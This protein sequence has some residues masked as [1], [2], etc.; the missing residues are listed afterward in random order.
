MDT[1]SGLVASDI[2]TTYIS[3]S[4]NETVGAEYYQIMDQRSKKILGT[5]ID[6]TFTSVSL[7]PSTSYQFQVIP[8]YQS[9]LFSDKSGTLQ[10]TT[11]AVRKN[12]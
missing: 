11:A 5:T 3:I 8:A 4:W 12:P 1:L 9:T 7:I 2:G 10:V 6:T